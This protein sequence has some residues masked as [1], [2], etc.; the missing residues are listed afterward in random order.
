LILLLTFLIKEKSK[1]PPARRKLANA[2]KIFN[3]LLLFE[4]L[5][6]FLY[7]INPGGVRV[8][9][10]PMLQKEQGNRTICVN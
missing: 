4:K 3:L 8:G 1:A 6:F 10:I 5:L 9:A 2:E 7:K